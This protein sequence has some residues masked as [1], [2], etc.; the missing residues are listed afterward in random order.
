MKKKIINLL[1]KFTRKYPF[2]GL[3]WLLKFIY[4]PKKNGFKEI[5]TIINYDND[6][7]ININTS[8]HIEYITF[9]WGYYEPKVTKLIKK[10][11]NSGDVAI[12][13]GANVGIHTLIMSKNV[14]TGRVL[15]FEPQLDILKRLKS[16][17]DL[18]D[19]KN[20]E[21]SSLALSNKEK[22]KVL[23]TH[24]NSFYNKGESSFYKEHA[25]GKF[26]NKI[27]VKVST[28]DQV[29][30]SKNI[31]S[32]SLIKID[33]EGEDLNIIRGAKETLNNFNPCIIFE[34]EK[35]SWSLANNTLK[36]AYKFFKK[37]GYNLYKVN[38]NIDDLIPIKDINNQKENFI[39]VMA[40]KE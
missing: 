30:K 7:K 5:E 1:S 38:N 25:N 24:N 39:T 26:S 15:A 16:N 33:T 32:I 14:G 9:F 20:I 34:Y 19:I 35:S 29:I 37:L 22:E 18:N 36:D 6:L 12:D 11:L 3:G 23:Y 2:K 8:S 31:K 4:N 21:V 40:K 27:N 10:Y 13:V 28:I 17:I